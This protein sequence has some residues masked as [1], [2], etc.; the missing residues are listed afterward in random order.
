MFITCNKHPE[1]RYN[2]FFFLRKKG[3]FNQNIHYEQWK[4]EHNCGFVWPC[5]RG[6]TLKD[7]TG[8][9]FRMWPLAVLTGCS[10]KKMYGVLPGQTILNVITR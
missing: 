1:C 2:F 9:D 5:K 7:Y 3:N 10:K 8:W 4:D 6:K